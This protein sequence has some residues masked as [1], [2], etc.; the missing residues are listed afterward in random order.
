[1]VKDTK[2]Y[3]ILEIPTDATDMDIKKAYKNL[4]RKWHP[5]KN[6]D[7]KDE[8]TKKFQEI[9]EA[10]A[11]LGDPEKRESYD[12]NGKDNMNMPNFD[13]SDLFNAAFG[14]GGASFENM[15]GGSHPFFRG[16]NGNSDDNCIVEQVV[17]LE[18]LYCKKK[19]TVKYTQKNYCSK[20]N[21]TGTKDGRRMD[22]SGCKGQGKKFK[23]VKQGPTIQQFISMCDECNGSG[24]Q[25]SKDNI[26]TECNGKKYITK[27]ASFTIQ[28]DR[29]MSNNDKM[30]IE[31]MGHQYK[32][33]KSNLIVVLKEQPHNI[34]K[35]QGKDLHMDIKLRLYQSLYGFSKMITHLDGRQ[36]LLKYDKMLNQ[37]ITTMKVRN[38]GMGGHLILHIS[39]MMP[40]I[41]RLDDKENEILRKLLVKAHL[42]EYQ[43]EQAILENSSKMDTVNLEEITIQENEREHPEME[44]V[45]CAQQ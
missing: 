3:D 30:M 15:F 33:R 14:G 6:I 39:T 24:E 40:K 4:S 27:E 11:I 45:Q 20:C 25:V 26:C 31:N 44:G 10:Y 36:I 17:T 35:R 7:N 37:M 34:F 32:N 23:V 41:S 18:D 21:E 8:A 22:C 38:E 2:L 9:S 1:M 43:K 16:R 19:I 12:R 42:A 29:H 13:P 5:D 28:L